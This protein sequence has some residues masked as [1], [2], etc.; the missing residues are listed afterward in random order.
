MS[1]YY[2]QVDE[3]NICRCIATEECN[4]HK[5]KLHMKKL[6]VEEKSRP[7]D[8]IEIL[9][10]GR[11]VSRINV[12]QRPENYPQPTEDEIR[13]QKIQAEMR[14]LAEQSLIA[15]GEIQAVEEKL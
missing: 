11:D 1:K 7:G 12:I 8:E 6:L 4:L 10:E 2:I 14:K 9:E 13:E 5:D 15:K 3:N